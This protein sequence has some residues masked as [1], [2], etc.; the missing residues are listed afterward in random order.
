MTMQK[1]LQVLLDKQAITE[2]INKHARS[3]DRMDGDNATAESYVWAYQVHTEEG[4]D[5]EGILGG[6]HY[7]K[8][9]RRNGVWKI[10]H[11]LN[12]V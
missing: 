8:F 5:K 9:E 2:V 12:R 4:V 10:S 7:Y 11:T 1:Q 6:R 3:L